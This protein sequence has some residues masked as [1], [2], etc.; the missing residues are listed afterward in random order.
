[1]QD[2]IIV[3][4]YWQRDESALR[5]TEI[6]YGSYLS[7]VSFNI[8]SDKEDA[9][10][11]LNETLLCAWNSMPQQRPKLLGTYL[12]KITR[13][14]SIDR[15]RT[16]HR[17][18]RI[19]SQFTLSLDELSDIAVDDSGGDLDCILLGESINKYLRTL[20]HEARTAFVQRYF[21]SDPISEIAKRQGCSESRL[22]SLLFRVR[23]GLREHL[24]KEGY[25]I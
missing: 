9:R 14:L 20:S 13:D 21:F 17:K 23:K 19:D 8:L 15:Y 6:K 18:K 2:E 1:M 7:K 3:E 10:E 4:L 24:I 12:S 11:I 16:K 25:D 5:E 22:K